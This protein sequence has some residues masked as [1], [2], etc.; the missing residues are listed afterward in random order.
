VAKVIKEAEVEKEY[1]IKK[2]YPV[3]LYPFKEQIVEWT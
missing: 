2:P 1:K 3:I